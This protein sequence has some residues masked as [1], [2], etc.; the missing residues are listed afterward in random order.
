[1]RLDR[2]LA[3][4]M[5]ATTGAAL[6][7]C[8]VLDGLGGYH[9]AGNG[10]ASSSSSSSATGAGGTLSDGGPDAD[11]HPE[12]G[13]EP[14]KTLWA[15]SF[16]DGQD[17]TV[18]AVALGPQG[19]IFITGRGNGFTGFKCKL[20]GPADAGDGGLGETGLGYLV[21]L[22]PS[23]HCVW[24]FFFGGAGNVEGTAV[25]A[26]P[27][28]A[29]VLAGKFDSTITLPTEQGPWTLTS[30]AGFDSFLI[31][32]N[33][34]HS[35]AWTRVLTDFATFSDQ[36][37]KSL[38]AT[39]TEI[40]VGVQFGG[41]LGIETPPV[42]VP[43]YLLGPA[44]GQD[45]T[46]L[47]VD[48][49]ANVTNQL[50]F[51]GAADQTLGGVAVRS[52]G[53]FGTTGQTTSSTFINGQL[54]SGTPNHSVFLTVY[55]KFK[56]VQIQSIFPGDSTQMG[57]RLALDEDA[58]ATLLAGELLGSITLADAGPTLVDM[59]GQ[60]VFV[61][62]FQQSGAL[63]G[64][65]Q[66]GSDDPNATLTVSGLGLDGNHAVVIG[67]SFTG[68]AS[69]PDAS[70]VTSTSGNDMYVAK[71]D[72]ALATPL[73]LKSCKTTTPGSPD[74]GVDGLV[75]DGMGNTTVV[76]HFTGS[77]D[78]GDGTSPL[79]STGKHDIFVAKLGP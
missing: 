27:D 68:Q 32:F 78:C 28:G 76:G 20:A 60:H 29:I 33:G 5:A 62:G 75:V 31:R 41:S 16:G 19:E 67:G 18:D 65:I 3:L 34:D 79:T 59:T 61:A 46:V 48:T 10:G 54:V 36:V 63:L 55:D 6:V 43:A 58:G 14:G 40:V 53:T 44:G 2:V 69:F 70:S 9:F 25:A 38:A 71:V 77:L 73:W 17:Q 57:E 11:A 49:A 24:G 13:P 15:T 22:D 37:V 30:S 7:S 42:P 26:A 1:M 72:R 66:L 23:G 39:S 45:V 50:S 21:E 56:T 74:Q 35:V 52:D 8:N 4:G 51:G 64:A 47:L 12:A